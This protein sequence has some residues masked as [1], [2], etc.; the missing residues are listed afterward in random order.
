MPYDFINDKP[1]NKTQLIKWNRAHVGYYVYH[2]RRVYDG[3]SNECIELSDVQEL[4]ISRGQT[5]ACLYNRYGENYWSRCDVGDTYKFGSTH[6]MK[7]SV[8][9]GR[10]YFAEYWYNREDAE[11]HLSELKQTLVLKA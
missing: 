4:H 11:K 1:Q 9:N 8:S 7:T 6:Y 5:N 10:K 2:I 3:I